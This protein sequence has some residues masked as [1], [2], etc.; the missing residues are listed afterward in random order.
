MLPA[1]GPRPTLKNEEQITV[2]LMDDN[3][4]PRLVASNQSY[5]KPT[6][7]DRSRTSY[8]PQS[9]DRPAGSDRQRSSE[10][11]PSEQA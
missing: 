6:S 9:F 3:Q 7:Y 1:R 5:E 8:R 4:V 11:R 2:R 10:Q